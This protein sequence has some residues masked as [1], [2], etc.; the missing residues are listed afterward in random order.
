M[1]SQYFSIVT[2][3]EITT[4]K[5]LLTLA[6][7]A[8][9]VPGCA[10]QDVNPPQARSNTG[11]VDFHADP[12]G[13]LCWEV[14]RFDD[15]SQTFRRVFSE[16]KPP[17]GGVLRLVFAPGL[18]RLRI[19]FLNRVIAAPTE[20]EVEVQDGKITPVRITLTEVGT[21]SVETREINSAAKSRYGQRTK[22][23]SRETIMYKLA[24]TAEPPVGYQPREQMPNAR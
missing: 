12:P 6:V 20:I 10:T 1:S 2:L 24:S 5:C 4:I 17:P 11:Y 22:I 14:S 15:R 23:D 16:L 21:A 19:T 13:E 8:L 9:M 7:A 3:R 18:H